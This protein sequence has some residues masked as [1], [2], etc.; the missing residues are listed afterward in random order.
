MALITW[1]NDMSVGNAKIDAQ[2]KELISIIN[3]LADA[4][5]KGTASNVLGEI[6]N[7]LVRYTSVHFSDEERIFSKTA[8]P[9][10]EA[11]KAKH[12][13]LMVKVE[14][15][16]SDYAAGKMALSIP[17][18]DFL[19]KWLMEHIMKSDKTYSPYI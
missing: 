12:K 15:I 19:K 18:L 13:F 10:T 4:M 11:H 16:K 8:Y 3:K 6:V 2:H 7:E 17:V 5:Q 14:S 9:D 1:T